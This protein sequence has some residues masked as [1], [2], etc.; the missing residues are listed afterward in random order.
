[1]IST[2]DYSDV[3]DDDEYEVENMAS[4]G[5][6]MYYNAEGWPYYYN[7]ITGESQWDRPHDFQGESTD[8]ICGPND[9]IESDNSR[10]SFSDRAQNDSATQPLQQDNGSDEKFLGHDFENVVSGYNSRDLYDVSEEMVFE[11]EYRTPVTSR[12]VRSGEWISEGTGDSSGHEFPGHFSY[13]MVPHHHLLWIRHEQLRSE[14]GSP[15]THAAKRSPILAAIQLS[16][17]HHFHQQ[18]HSR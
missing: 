5:W 8:N 17:F 12:K 18:F 2:A 1:M 10:S 6:T 14:G 11:S 16:L 7:Q 13:Y 4:T 3:D 15:R 9:S